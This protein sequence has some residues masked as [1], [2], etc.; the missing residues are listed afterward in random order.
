[1]DFPKHLHHAY[2]IEGDIASAREALL[3]FLKKNFDMRPGNPDLFLFS[4]DS[5]GIEDGRAITE[6][7]LRK[8]LSSSGKK[9]IIADFSSISS[10][11]QNSLLKTL[12]EPYPGTHIFLITSTSAVFLP[13]V[14]S[15]T[16]VV[17]FS[18]SKKA[19][20][21]K[22]DFDAGDMARKFLSSKPAER[23]E[24]IKALMAEKENDK[25]N[26]ADVESFIAEAERLAHGHSKNPQELKPFLLADEYI[27]DSSSSTKMLLEYIA[28]RLP[29][30]TP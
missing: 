11:A 28:L 21:N 22:T 7:G 25:I 5:F 17:R 19:S 30:Y 15:R 8:A 12:E 24:M 16:H 29:E 9:F 20:D 10:Q 18:G 14:L 13:T 27:R 2:I 6:A 26:D 23:I 3:A 1:M 4:A